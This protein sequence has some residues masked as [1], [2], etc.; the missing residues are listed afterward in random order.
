M[1]RFLFIGGDK[2]MI[3]AAREVARHYDTAAFGLCSE[4]PAPGGLYNN[5]VL[6][7]PFSR[8]GAL[9]TAPLFSEPIALDKFAEFAAEN[10]VVYSGGSS[11]VLEA[12]CLDSGFTLRNYLADESLALKNAFL[13]A[14]AA[15]AMLIEHRERS[16]RGA[17]VLITG[18][19]RIARCLG[20]ILRGFGAEIVVFA[21][22]AEQRTLAELDGLCAIDRECL[23]AAAITS[24]III[25]TAPAVLFNESCLRSLR[26][27]AVYMELA[28]L[29]AEP[30]AGIVKSSGGTHIMASGLPG[31]FF[32]QSAGEAVAE[33]LLQAAQ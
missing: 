32:P 18:Y 9:I 13:T 10:A 31:R 2:R 6:P 30:L 28:S 33:Y 25:N 19:G 21:R 12:F 24:D 1:D 7:L 20:R 4:F 26:K 16:L 22:R 17:S 15:A 29:S 23:C 27:G 5:I 11:A 3:Y 8:G 14:E